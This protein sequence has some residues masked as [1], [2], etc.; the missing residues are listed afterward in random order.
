MKSFLLSLFI[1]FAFLIP[2]FSQLTDDFSDVDFT[3]NPT[4]DKNTVGDEHIRHTT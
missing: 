3:A 1:Y 4:F 2:A